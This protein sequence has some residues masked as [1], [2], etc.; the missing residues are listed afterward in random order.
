MSEKPHLLI[1][2]TNIWIEAY[3]GWRK[4]HKEANELIAFARNHG[5]ELAYAITTVKDVYYLIGADLK[6]KERKEKGALSQEA[7][8]A[9]AEIS[10]A[11]TI[12]MNEVATPIGMD[13][14]D[15]WMARKLRSI[16]NDLEDNLVI[17][18]GERANADYI[19]TSDAKL[20]A[21]PHVHVLTAADMLTH[22][23]LFA[24]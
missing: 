2:D 14:A 24:A 11:V 12:N 8:D 1:L 23:Q 15:V 3:L 22:L 5:I 6:W 9:I 10:W 18:A 7:A 4:G 20:L 13:L 21:N 17:A 16:H 19:V